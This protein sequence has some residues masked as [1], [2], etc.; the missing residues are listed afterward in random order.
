MKV[1]IQGQIVP[2]HD[3]I[4]PEPHCISDERFILAMCVP[5]KGGM[6]VFENINGSVQEQSDACNNDGGDRNDP[7]KNLKNFTENLFHRYSSL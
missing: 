7:Q 5:V 4:E 6:A 3:F 1:E 2:A